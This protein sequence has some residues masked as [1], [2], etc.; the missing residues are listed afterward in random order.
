MIH[1]RGRPEI[2]A[3]HETLREAA[4]K[5]R[6]PTLLVRGGR[7]RVVSLEGVR[8]LQELIPKAAYV[9]IDKADHMVAGDD[10]DAFCS[11][12]LDFLRS[13]IG[14]GNEVR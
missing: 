4:R 1:G 14:Q 6:C 11:P 5:V 7:S 13:I 9:N 10:N 3:I 8:E 12:L 2:G